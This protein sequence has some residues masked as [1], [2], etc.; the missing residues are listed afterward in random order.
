MKAKEQ[1]WV[2]NLTIE[3]CIFPKTILFFKI[4][5]NVTKK[6][7]FT[8][9]IH[10]EELMMN[11]EPKLNIESQNNWNIQTSQCPYN[12]FGRIGFL[13]EGKDLYGFYIYDQEKDYIEEEMKLAPAIRRRMF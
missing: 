3:E 11:N 7:K 6:D 5:T 1:I 13:N 12:E 4:E 10:L 8:P 2:G 9:F